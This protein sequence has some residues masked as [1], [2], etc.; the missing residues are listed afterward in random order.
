MLAPSMRNWFG[1]GGAANGANAPRDSN[2]G[3]VGAQLATGDAPALVGPLVSAG[4]PM[5]S[6]PVNPPA[7]VAP[8][9]RDRQDIVDA[10]WGDGYLFPGGEIE[11]MRLAKPLG[12]S[13]A[14]SLLL[15]GAGGGGPACSLASKLGVWVNGFESD[16]D[17]IQAANARIGRTKLGKRAQV[18]A[19]DP[20]APELA[21]HYYHHS[22]ALEPLHGSQPEPTLAAIAA[23]IKPG[24]QLMLVELVADAPLDPKDPE[25][26][27]WAR[28]ERRNP[29]TL[30]SEVA[31][32]RVLGRLGFDI[33][34]VE[35]I[36]RRHMEQAMMGWRT[37]VR[38]LEDIRPN[39]R[40]AGLIVHEA[41][42]WLMRMRLFGTGRLRLVRW[43]AIGRG[44]A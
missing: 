7:P 13:A 6:Q 2:A 42:L 15:L 28:L 43:H 22:L 9:S 35:N 36:S 34:I 3:V 31:I 21:R 19:W 20:A 41:E 5:R 38:D 26:A 29:E 18:E 32:T 16:P 1:R 14:S 27:R 11:T 8:W 39:R 4:A 30:P 25:V 40:Q 17:L 37:Q 33:R 44:S 23:A 12:L 10:L 24:G